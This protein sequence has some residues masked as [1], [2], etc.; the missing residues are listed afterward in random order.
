MNIAKLLDKAAESFGDRPAVSVGRAQHASYA[1]LQQRAATL[2]RA[3][4]EELMLVEGD[5]VAIAMTNCAPFLEVLF[6]IW[7][8]GLSA[9]PMNARLHQREFHYILSNSGARC[10]FVNEALRETVAPLVDEIETLSNVISVEDDAYARLLQGEAMPTADVA[11]TDTAWLFYTSG[12]T[13]RPKGA[14]LTHR[15]LLMMSLSY[16]ADI[17]ALGPHDTMLHP[18]PLT[19]GSGLFSL[20]HIGK[21][22][23]HVIPE[24]GHFE[25]REICELIQ[26]YPNTSFFA[27]PTM[28]TR[29]INS[30]AGANNAD[31][32][33]LKS[34]VYGGS[35]MYVADLERAIDIMG[36]RLVQIYGQGESPCTISYLGKEFHVDRAH[37]RY[38][39]RSGSAGLARTDV[40]I[41]IADPDD[42]TVPRG[43]LGEIL[44]RG[45]V[46]MAGY[47]QNPEATAET[48]RGGWLH[49]GDVGV[50]DEDGFLTLKDRSKDMLISGGVN[51]YPRVIEEVLLLHEAVQETSV[52]GR[53]HPDWGEEVVAF[54]VRRPGA[55]VGEPELE[56]L[57][58]D[59]IARFKRPK[60]YVFVDDLPKNNYGKVLKTELRERLHRDEAS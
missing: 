55:D 21:A 22:S 50:M 7:Q 14:S 24:S 31:W 26:T 10:C 45:D 20:A 43:E 56:Q 52:V 23:H 47:W 49:T 40:E 2:A 19:H 57:C 11:P 60:A 39:E 38:L 16:Y 1:E 3:L 36:P 13:G 51:I 17:D 53:P 41:R 33:N 18:A 42:E 8:A 28:L 4:R 5:A 9:V 48:L 6:G 54:V 29:L 12:T 44:V 30:D 58:L 25:P 35:A 37:P 27:A 59:N 32:G 15:N 46:V 34:I